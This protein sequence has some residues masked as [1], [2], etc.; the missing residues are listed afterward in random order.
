MRTFNSNSAISA[1]VAPLEVARWDQ[2]GLGGKMPFDA[3]WYTVPAGQSSH[4]DCHPELEL[5]LIISG[6]A[7]VEAGG[8]IT[9][10]PTGSAF[11]FD[12]E[13]PHIVHNRSQDVPL[14]IFS[15][16]WM[17]VEAVAAGGVD[18]QPAPETQPV[19]SG[20]VPANSIDPG[21]ESPNA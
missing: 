3:M 19:D 1:T 5:S 17:P 13:E 2:Y 21:S 12:S 7:F 9:E 4:R 6:T 11:L 18:L 15:A 10:L 8:G 16:F 14:T 20:A